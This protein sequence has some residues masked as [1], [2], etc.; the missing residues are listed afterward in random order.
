M[1]NTYDLKTL[2][3]LIMPQCQIKVLDKIPSTQLLAKKLVINN[4]VR[5][6]S[7][8]IAEEQTNGQGRFGR[9]FFHQQ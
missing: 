8:Y 4:S 5:K 9:E 2:R 1:T 6:L 3:Q 7:A